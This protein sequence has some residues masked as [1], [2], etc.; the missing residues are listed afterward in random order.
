MDT[1]AQI[2]YVL[3]Q[4]KVDQATAERL[5]RLVKTGGFK[6]KY[7]LVQYLVSVFLRFADPE[8]EPTDEMSQ[9]HYQWA[10]M[11]QDWSNKSARI[12]TSKPSTSQALRLVSS[13]NIYTEVGKKGYVARMIKL[14][15]KDAD[16]TSTTNVDRAVNEV[17]QKLYPSVHEQLQCVA[18]ACGSRRDIDAIIALLE[19]S[20]I[21]TIAPDEVEGLDV[22]M[23]DYGNVPVRHNNRNE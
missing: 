16:M 8:H 4:T 3:V 22:A 13:L 14:H 17:L 6:S 2:K 20:D 23:N 11:L 19:S 7:E 15:G 18:H 1:K 10:I 12:I 21:P 5:E 9:E